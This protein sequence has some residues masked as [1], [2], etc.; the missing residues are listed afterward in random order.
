MQ[1]ESQPKAQE[2]ISNVNKQKVSGA[3]VHSQS[4]F[5]K[6]FSSLQPSPPLSSLLE[7]SCIIVL[8]TLLSMR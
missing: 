6:A 4:D 1:R 3:E 8:C 7:I 2:I 5:I